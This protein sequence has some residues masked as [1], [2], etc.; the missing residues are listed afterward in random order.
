MAD[1]FV[2]GPF[3]Y[4]QMARIQ[5]ARGRMEQ[6]ERLYLDA[7]VEFDDTGLVVDYASFLVDS[8]RVDEAV[9]SLRRLDWDDRGA[10]PAYRQLAQH[11]VQAGH[12]DSA[13]KAFAAGI[14]RFPQAA[15]LYRDHAK[16]LNE[17]G[18]FADAV[19]V[20]N[21]LVAIKPLDAANWSPLVYMIARAERHAE[22]LETLARARAAM[23]GSLDALCALGR[24]AERSLMH[25]SA[26][27]LF[28]EAVQAY[29]DDPRA[30]AEFGGYFLRQGALR[31]ALRHL[32]QAVALDPGDA[33]V[34]SDLAYVKGALRFLGLESDDGPA[35][36]EEV[37][38]PEALFPVVRR[39]HEAGGRRFDYRPGRAMIVTSSL[40]AGGAE[41]QAANTVTELVRAHPRV[42][43]VV[44]GAASLSTR[45]RRNFYLSRIRHLPID[46][47]SLEDL[48]IEDPLGHPDVEPFREILGYFTADIRP[49]IARWI[50]VFSAQRPQVVHT[51]QDYINIAAGVAALLVGVPRLVM[52][53]RN[54][55]PDN[56]YRRLKRYMHTAYNEMVKLP[57]VGLINNSIAGARDYEAWLGLREGECGVIWNGLNLSSLTEQAREQSDM[58][59]TLGI[60]DGVP[61]MGGVFRMSDE[62][63][64]LL[65]LDTA[66]IVARAHPDAHFIMCGDGVLY[67]DVR[68]YADQLGLSG[69]VHL[70]GMIS[71]IGAW[72]GAMTIFLLASRKEGLP[73]VLIEAQAFG[74]PVVSAN[75]GGAAE[76]IIAGETGW[77]VDDA[78]AEQLADRVLWCLAR[79][80]W[81]EACKGKAPGFVNATF[82]LDAM[83]AKTLTSYQL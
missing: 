52:G 80:D 44:L 62:K 17:R 3:A 68:D 35:S 28:A 46:I 79:P 33:Q 72:Y 20:L 7:L 4:R 6:A 63:R 30:C 32:S 51:W 82:S 9:E 69:R 66:A 61:V 37:L 71:N 53:T 43:S 70:P 49:D 38:L 50:I 74:M 24:V 40:T 25:D 58:R 77:A 42:D 27:A 16:L 31:S 11:L 59:R 55:R 39:L 8:G 64:P 48:A 54:T 75:V 2:N 56:K 34:Q 81:M 83:A 1:D 76:V 19:A 15:A 13:L 22:A 78:D 67:N 60:P 10:V 23:G 26:E 12:A 41:R 65:W 45:R 47:V 57:S 21:R 18:K 73:N 5:V 36:G 29:P 14:G